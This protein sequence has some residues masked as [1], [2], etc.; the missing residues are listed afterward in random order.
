MSHL[1]FRRM[2]KVDFVQ[3]FLLVVISWSLLLCASQQAA[4]QMKF[5]QVNSAVPTST[6]TISATYNSAQTA[7]NMNVV[8][9]GWDSSFITLKTLTDSKGN[10]YKLAVS[11]VDSTGITQAIYY[12]PN[13]VAA[14]AG[15]NRVTAT[16][17][18]STDWPDLRIL[19]YSGVNTLD[20]TA[21]AKGTTTTASSGS[22]TTTQADE[23]LFGA[24]YTYGT[25]NGPGSG[26]TSRV[27][28]GDS[29]LAEDEVV[30]TTGLYT[31]KASMD[32]QEWVAQLATF[33]S[34]GTGGTTLPAPTR[35]TT[36]TASTSQINLSWTASS[37]ATSYNV[38]RSTTSGGPYAQG[39]CGVT[40]TSYSDTGLTALTTYYYVVQ[41]VDAGGTSANSSP[42]SATTQVQSVSVT[43]S[44]TSVALAP[45]AT[46]Q[47][48][49]TVTGSSNT[50]V[51]WE[52]NGVTGGNSTTG[53]VSTSGLYTAPATV[54]NPA[55]VTV[56]AVLQADTTKSAS[57]TVTISNSLAFYVSTTGNDASSGTS[58]SPWRTIQ[59]AANMVQPGDTIYVYGGTYN[60]TVTINASGNSTA[61]YITFQSYPGQ[62]AIIDGTGLAVNGQTG[63][64]NIQDQS[65]LVV[66]G[67][68]I[69][70][71]STSSTANVP[72]GIYI[73]GADSY[74]QI[75]N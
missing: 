26:Y 55:N 41:A 62:T 75:L 52:V 49:A 6:A 18:A 5:V 22:V 68:E 21:S 64:I 24:V 56:T 28:T 58:G 1:S 3:S 33:Y 47:F 40:S 35:L 23:L 8:A 45:N 27:E 46:Q 54:P 32:G 7:G 42:A 51:T 14:A 50:A 10:S 11:Y 53:T 69:R 17:S 4:A 12:A 43:I 73:T 38:L 66:R 72:I 57:A 37:G 59:H 2:L 71:Y 9:I 15:A 48:T 31:A 67:F 16:L 61:G 13:I 63:L 70:N 60:E 74:I 34:S 30:F 20:K 65:Y 19:E 44:P 25:T 39:A 36:S 29:D